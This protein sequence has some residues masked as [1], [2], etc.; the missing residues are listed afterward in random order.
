MNN[1]LKKKVQEGLLTEKDNRRVLID[2]LGV[3]EEIANWAHGLSD[4]LS[5]WIVKSLKDK[6]ANEMKGVSPENQVSLDEF[7]RTVAGDYEDIMALLRKPNKPKTDI[8]TLNFDTAVDLVN[9][10][11]YIEAWLDDPANQAQAEHGQGFLTNKTWEEA[12]AMADAWHQSLTAGGE[13]QDLLDDKD[14]VIHTFDNGFQWVLRK[15]STCSKSKESMGH[16][17]TATKP[18]M[19]LLRLIKGN[20][21]FITA[22]WDPDGKFIVQ[23]KGLNNKKPISKYHPYIAWLIKDWGGVAKLKTNTGYLPQT[24]FQLG[25]LDPA[26]AA[27]IIGKNPGI[28]GI[29]SI[30]SFTP[31]ENKPKLIANLFKYDSFID[32][33]IPNGFADFFNM[34][35]NKNMVIGA[36]LK[37]PTFLEK[38]NKYSGYLTDTL[39]RLLANTT[40]K[41]EVID[42]LLK[43]EGLIPML[44]AEGEDVLIDNHS[45]PDYVRNILYSGDEMEMDMDMAVTENTIKKFILTELRKGLNF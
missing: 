45:N 12:V 1:W 10:Y 7:Y 23:L 16:C 40:R 20:S 33:L 22:D 8:N 34:V 28:Q 30:L 38:M 24:N 39:E 31:T 37:N 32:K 35:E 41:D 17:A 29:H 25:E 42:L 21:E 26:L 36:V 4:K 2:K 13:V 11:R 44:D 15:S 43:R 9:K 5:I 18:N 3:S 27:E 19:Y 6:Y 14:E